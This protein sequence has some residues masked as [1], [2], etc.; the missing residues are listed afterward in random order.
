MKV[1]QVLI[2][3]TICVAPIN[4]EFCKL[5]L[6]NGYFLQGLLKP[7]QTPN[8]LCR[9]IKN[10]CC[11]PNDI[12][13]LHDLS[14]FTL[15][16]KQ[17]QFFIKIQQSMKRI[18][19]LHARAVELRHCDDLRL[20]HRRFC[21]NVFMNLTQFP[22]HNLTN[23]LVHS[24]EVAQDNYFKMHQGFLCSLCDAEAQANILL[25]TQQ[26]SQADMICLRMLNENIEFLQ[27]QNIQMMEYLLRMQRHLDCSYYDSRFN[28]MFPFQTEFNLFRDFSACYAKLKPESLPKECLG[29]CGQFKIGGF[30][31]V[32]EGNWLFF[33]RATEYFQS[34]IRL[35]NFKRQNAPFS[36]LRIISGINNPQVGFNFIQMRNRTRA[37]QRFMSNPG[38]RYWVGDNHWSLPDLFYNTEQQYRQTEGNRKLVGQAKDPSQ[39]LGEALL[40]KFPALAS[41]NNTSIKKFVDSISK[42]NVEGLLT[43]EY[44]TLGPLGSLAEKEKLKD[45]SFGKDP[46]KKKRKSPIQNRLLKQGI[47]QE[48][49]SDYNLAIP[50]VPNIDKLVFPKDKNS[51]PAIAV[52][53]PILPQV[54][55]TVEQVAPIAEVKP[56]PV[57][58]SSVAEN[59]GKRKLIEG[60]LGLIAPATF[61]KNNPKVHIDIP[62]ALEAGL[63]MSGNLIKRSQNSEPQH[64]TA[65]AT[66]A[67]QL[68]PNPTVNV[69]QPPIVNVA[70]HVT[71]APDLSLRSAVPETTQ[72]N[73]KIQTKSLKRRHSRPNRSMRINHQKRVAY[74][75]KRAL[76]MRRKRHLRHHRRPERE[77]YEIP[78]RPPVYQHN[79]RYVIERRVPKYR[80]VYRPIRKRVS[81]RHQRLRNRRILTELFR[82]EEDP[83]SIENSVEPESEH[84]LPAGRVLSSIPPPDPPKGA[85]IRSYWASYYES[86][87]FIPDLK[88]REIYRPVKLS[89]DMFLFNNTLTA[90]GGLNLEKYTHSLNF[91]IDMAALRKLLFS[92]GNDDPKDLVVIA[93]P[94]LFNSAFSVDLV[95]CMLVDVSLQIPPSQLSDDDQE[96]LKREPEYDPDELFTEV[97]LSFFNQSPNNQTQIFNPFIKPKDAYRRLREIAKVNRKLSLIDHNSAVFPLDSR[98]KKEAKRL[99]R[100]KAEVNLNDLF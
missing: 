46:T 72:I 70:E 58:L 51:E 23:H 61:N 76:R 49:L 48:S 35:I 13:K 97:D 81:R 39:K 89:G 29:I 65:S 92:T 3:L 8:P 30:T 36:P 26:Y 56:V 53:A 57:T 45:P 5:S 60:P 79:N 43:P 40:N 67:P 83:F 28:F 63:L 50:K 17:K 52:S 95:K 11:S 91:D 18:E 82:Q 62:S 66:Q 78:L 9:S 24:L 68:I 12:I 80:T 22:I 100:P 99:G 88:S 77:L 55:A 44:G 90:D 59:L 1:F 96:L 32:F 14:E 54:A 21:Q 84:D 69:V 85:K 47:I 71:N 33:N 41:V 37:R 64:V 4:S 15:R 34:M 19:R 94:K 20:H 75:P 73:P 6:M 87:T 38:N 2:A 86:I 16:P 93:I 25:E 7:S 10:N 74:K 31:P 98:L 27:A 42:M